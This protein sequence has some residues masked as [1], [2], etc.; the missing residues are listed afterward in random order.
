MLMSGCP[1]RRHFALDGGSRPR[2]WPLTSASEE[3]VTTDQ[4]T[5]LYRDL[6]VAGLWQEMQV[7]I[8][9]FREEGMARGSRGGMA[10]SRRDHLKSKSG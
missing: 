8:F 9:V 6:A 7:L 1:G 10:G 2:T 5:G 4:A 3:Y